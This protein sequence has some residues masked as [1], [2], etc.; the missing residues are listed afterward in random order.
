MD[1]VQVYNAAPTAAEI[2]TLYRQQAG[3][4]RHRLLRW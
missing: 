1:N 2:L 3:T 4:P